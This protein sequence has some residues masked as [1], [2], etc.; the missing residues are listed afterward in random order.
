M[1]SFL[2]TSIEEKHDLVF[3]TNFIEDFD[4]RKVDESRVHQTV[5]NLKSSSLPNWIYC[6]GSIDDH[7]ADPC[8][9]KMDR[10]GSFRKAIE[11]YAQ[12]FPPFLLK[13]NIARHFIYFKKF[14]S[15]FLVTSIS[16]KM[17]NGKIAVENGS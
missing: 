7:I 12:S 6:N 11:F 14:M 10:S 15:S 5:D 4:P 16:F 8:Q 9:W 17:S 1:S 3:N 2:V 13:S